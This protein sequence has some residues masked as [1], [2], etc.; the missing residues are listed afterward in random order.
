MTC[1][2]TN[3]SIRG[4]RPWPAYAVLISSKKWGNTVGAPRIPPPG[5]VIAGI[6]ETS[7]T[8]FPLWHTSRT[9]RDLARI[10]LAD[11]RGWLAVQ[12]NLQVSGS[13]HSVGVFWDTARTTL[14]IPPI[15]DT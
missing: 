14:R 10:Y 4:M 13:S 8:S 9:G 3:S 15:P 5:L 6:E 2:T 7:T 12:M 11:L 1:G